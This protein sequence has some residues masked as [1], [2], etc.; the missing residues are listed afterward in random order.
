ML[1]HQYHQATKF[2]KE[3]QVKPVIFLVKLRVPGAF[4][5]TSLG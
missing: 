1:Y 3:H 2:T 5:V 4:V